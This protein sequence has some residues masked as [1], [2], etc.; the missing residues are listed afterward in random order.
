MI[1]ATFRLR[2]AKEIGKR[3]SKKLPVPVMLSTLEMVEV[4]R[5]F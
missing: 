4:D 1:V 2:L 5:A 3:R